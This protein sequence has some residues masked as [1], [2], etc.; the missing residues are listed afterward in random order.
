MFSM[1]VKCQYQIYHIFRIL[2]SMRNA[3]EI[4]SQKNTNGLRMKMQQCKDS[5]GIEP[6]EYCLI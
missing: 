2:K 4:L 3:Q 6:W 5:A 1:V